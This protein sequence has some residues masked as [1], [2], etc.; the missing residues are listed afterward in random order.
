M[1]RSSWFRYCCPYSLLGIPHDATTK[2]IKKA[3]RAH[4]MQTHPDISGGETSQEF[5]KINAAYDVLKDRKRRAS[6]DL[7]SLVVK[8]DPTPP[9]PRQKTPPLHV[10]ATYTL[11]DLCTKRSTIQVRIKNRPQLCEGCNGEGTSHPTAKQTC[12]FCFGRGNDNKNCMVCGGLGFEIPRDYIC[13]SCRGNRYQTEVKS[14][15]DVPLDFGVFS[16][17]KVTFPGKGGCLPGCTPGDLVVEYHEAPHR[18]FVR[19]GH[20]L[21]LRKELLLAECLLG[22]EIIVPHV[23]GTVVKLVY[24]KGQG[25]QNILRVRGRGVTVAGDLLVAVECV[26]PNGIG[27]DRRMELARVLGA[28]PPSPQGDVVPAEV[29]GGETERTLVERLEWGWQNDEDGVQSEMGAPVQRI[30]RSWFEK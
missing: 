27:Q 16:G 13:K 25:M 19:R 20:D 9:G 4:A 7:Q 15:F 11:E 28:T 12:V 2:D 8:P 23:D 24:E 18:V 17:H 5:A 30:R 6:H 10:R 1:R 3:Y 22:C 14:Y 29:L 21:L 26:M